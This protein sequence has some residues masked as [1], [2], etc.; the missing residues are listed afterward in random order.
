M[1]LHR[2]LSVLTVDNDSNMRMSIA[3]Y[4]EGMGCSVHQASDGDEGLRMFEKHNPDLVFT[5]L[6]MPGV[7]GFTVVSEISKKRPETPVVILSGNNSVE[8]AV[9]A[10]RS[11]AWDYIIKPLHDFN[12]LDQV[13][14]RVLDRAYSLKTERLYKESLQNAVLS[15]NRQIFKIRST[16]P[17]TKLPVLSQVKERFIEMVTNNEFT[18][19]LFIILLELDNLKK[20]AKAFGNDCRSK[21]VL[22]L[23]QRLSCIVCQD[24]V[25]GMA[26]SDELLVMV[27]NST[28][29]K[30]YV[31]A[32]S[33]LLHDPIVFLNHEVHID[34]NMGIVIFPQDGESID[35]LLHHANIARAN[36]KNSG[37]NRHSFYSKEQLERVQ[38]QAALELS[39]RGA[40]KRNEFA[41]HYQPKINAKHNCVDGM[42]ALIRW[43]PCNINKLVSPEVFIPVLETMGIIAAAG[44]WAIETACSQYV[45]WRKNGMGAVTLSVNISA[46]QF[47]LG[48]L[49]KV[50]KTVLTDSGMEA[51][52]LCLELTEG[53]VVGDT[54][55]VVATMQELKKLGVK[56]SIDDFGTGYS[57]L[58]YLKN[59]PLDELKIDRSFIHNLPED[60]TSVAIV[61][62]ILTMSRQLNLR[63]VA[64]GVETAEQAEF[65]ASRGCHE[66]Q[67]FL[68]S[69][70]LAA[71]AFFDWYCSALELHPQQPPN[72]GVD[73]SAT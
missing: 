53:I 22:E 68:F 63:V 70:P 8:Y 57:S 72:A 18:G 73:Q 19:D 64:E 28:E 27:S 67:G 1:T 14:D 40:L 21:M 6:L 11:G 43:I 69:P 36:A 45:K 17:L 5:D 61:E 3:T 55:E 23:A 56:L 50:I 35:T 32:V 31:S 26:G 41:I 34:Y 60:S 2:N 51:E 58:S 71:D 52:M 33:E 25:V 9:K 59:M 29:L 13:T 30:R 47:N 48:N 49:P 46:T 38:N 37:K 44:N 24:V 62:S 20:T 4:L 54:E 42:E 16:D 12:V 7:D 15:L 66:L 10:F 65:M 39:L